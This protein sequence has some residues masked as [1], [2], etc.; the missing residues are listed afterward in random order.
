MHAFLPML[1]QPALLGLLIS[2]DAGAFSAGSSFCLKIGAVITRIT[3]QAYQLTFALGPSQLLPHAYIQVIND[4]GALFNKSSV[5]A[6]GKHRARPIFKSMHQKTSGLL[7]KVI[8][9][10]IQNQHFR[11]QQQQNRQPYARALPR[12]QGS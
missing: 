6:G 8:R 12:R 2:I 10:L 5:M 4:S 3:H 1:A 7:I 11:G 9:G